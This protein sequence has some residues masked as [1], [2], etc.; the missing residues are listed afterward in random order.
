MRACFFCV[1][2]GCGSVQP[3][4]WEMSLTKKYALAKRKRGPKRPR[5]PPPAP[6]VRTC[7]GV[8]PA[9][10]RESRAALCTRIVGVCGNKKRINGYPG[11]RAAGRRRRARRRPATRVRAPAQVRRTIQRGVPGC[12]RA[13]VC[14]ACVWGGGGR[15][16]GHCAARRGAAQGEDSSDAAAPSLARRRSL[17]EQ[18]DAAEGAGGCAAA[19]A[20]GGGDGAGGGGSGGGAG[21]GAGGSAGGADEGFSDGSSDGIVSQLL[22]QMPTT[23]RAPRRRASGGGGG[24]SEGHVHV[25]TDGCAPLE[26]M[27]S[28]WPAAS[29]WVA[30][31][32]RARA[33]RGCP[34]ARHDPVRQQLRSG[35]VY[36][37]GLAGGQPHGYG[38][39][40]YRR[41]V[42]GRARAP[43]AVVCLRGEG[44]SQRSAVCGRVGAR[45]GVCRGRADERPGNHK[46]KYKFAS[47]NADHERRAR[48]R[49]W[50]A[51]Y[52][53]CGSRALLSCCPR[54]RASC[55]RARLSTGVCAGVRRARA[56]VRSDCPGGAT[57]VCA[58]LA[59]GSSD[60][61]CTRATGATA[62]STGTANS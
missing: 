48:V 5:A 3:E 11:V 56:R 57:V 54:R 44:R 42:C 12:A 20:G 55:T 36:E 22:P 27:G 53:G 7:A 46:C 8:R 33:V 18:T 59:C 29:Q 50:C 24:G 15:G 31:Q 61:A 10:R 21:G 1:A 13:R 25:V 43:A 51:S 2:C 60:A 34:L 39:V 32:V 26:A 38:T 23:S 52:R 28:R 9:T 14:V 16:G 41:F 30:A 49:W 19:A 17:T 35:D 4:V 62:C 58:G 6:M 37:G 45:R 40:V 47:A